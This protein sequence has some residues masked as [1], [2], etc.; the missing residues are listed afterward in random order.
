[1]KPLIPFANT[2]NPDNNIVYEALRIL[3]TNTFSGV[4]PIDTNGLW[5]TAMHIEDKKGHSGFIK[6]LIQDG[7]GEIVAYRIAEDYKYIP[8]E[9]DSELSMEH[10]LIGKLSDA[11]Q[12]MPDHYAQFGAVDH[13]PAIILKKI[14]GI[15]EFSEKQKEALSRILY[16]YSNSFVLVKYPLKLFREEWINIFVLYQNLAPLSDYIKN[17]E[18][19]ESRCFFREWIID[20]SKMRAGK[21]SK[22]QLYNTNDTSK[23]SSLLLN[24]EGIYHLIQDTSGLLSGTWYRIKRGPLAETYINRD[25]LL[26]LNITS[27]Y[28]AIKKRKTGSI[29]LFYNEDRTMPILDIK[30]ESN[31]MYYLGNAPNSNADKIPV[32][33]LLK[34]NSKTMKDFDK[35]TAILFLHQSNYEYSGYV[36]QEGWLYY[37]D[38]MNLAGDRNPYI[39]ELTGKN[40]PLTLYALTSKNLTL[41]KKDSFTVKTLN[42]QKGYLIFFSGHMFKADALPNS[43]KIERQSASYNITRSGQISVNNGKEN[44]SLALLINTTVEVKGSDKEQWNYL[45]SYNG[46]NYYYKGRIPPGMSEQSVTYSVQEPLTISVSLLEAKNLDGVPVLCF[47]GDKLEKSEEC[48]T[49]ERNPFTL[50]KVKRTGACGSEKNYHHRGFLGKATD[51]PKD[52]F[53]RHS[54]MEVRFKEESQV[55][56]DAGRVVRKDGFIIYKGDSAVSSKT[57]LFS[58]EIT[59]KTVYYEEYTRNANPLKRVSIGGDSGYVEVKNPTDFYTSRN[60][61]GFSIDSIETG[62]IRLGIE[63]FIGRQCLSGQRAIHVE[64]FLESLDGFKTGKSGRVIDTADLA[65]EFYLIK[66]KNDAPSIPLYNG[67]PHKELV[68]DPG[69]SI[70]MQVVRVYP[71]GRDSNLLK[72][73][74]SRLINAEIRLTHNR[75]GSKAVCSIGGREYRFSL[76]NITNGTCYAKP[77]V[78]GTRWIQLNGEG[79]IHTRETYLLTLIKEESDTIFLYR[80]WAHK[81]K[82]E[83]SY[84]IAVGDL[85][86]GKKEDI[87]SIRTNEYSYITL[88][89][90]LQNV[91]EGR[92][93]VLGCREDQVRGNPFEKDYFISLKDAV[94]LKARGNEWIRI[95]YNNAYYFA[96]KRNFKR[97]TMANNFWENP[98]DTMIQFHVLSLPFFALTEA[99]GNSLEC[100]IHLLSRLINNQLDYDYLRNLSRSE[101]LANLLYYG[102]TENM[103]YNDKPIPDNLY[104]TFNR[105]I[106]KCPSV[107]EWY[108]EPDPARYFPRTAMLFRDDEKKRYQDYLKSHLWMTTKVKESMGLGKTSG[109]PVGQ[110]TLFYYFHPI[111]F[112]QY[113]TQFF[114]FEFNPYGGKL[115]ESGSLTIKVVDNPGFAPLHDGRE[116]VPFYEYGNKMYARVSGLYNE[117][118]SEVGTYPRKFDEFYHEGVDFGAK[119]GTRIE[120]F[121]YGKVIAVGSMGS[122]GN[123]ILIKDSRKTDILY[124]LAHL[125]R[126]LVKEGDEVFP[127]MEVGE[128]GK[129]GGNYSPHLHLGIMKTEWNKKEHI[130]IFS[131]K[132]KQYEWKRYSQI[133]LPNYYNAFDHKDNNRRISIEK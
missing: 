18:P 41:V 78:W 71:P 108:D 65:N 100:N 105:S 55:V 132:S 35:E 1:M 17:R 117:D 67:V 113:V 70:S 6:P 24:K 2:T 129:T 110:I 83:I 50:V 53:S 21:V 75:S 126:P 51:S 38:E 43:K 39:A 122:Y 97:V 54:R 57:I 115:I 22:L 118:Y 7:N 99:G 23:K 107:W 44:I 3:E 5:H 111:N 120:S 72:I 13:P 30:K 60:R 101:R 114:N 86:F 82:P 9:H 74:P 80:I 119:E 79:F 42:N 94:T 16:S 31:F 58:D 130:V 28:Y 62:K 49:R 19:E 63:D 92:E 76:S 40:R 103:Y 131:E 47:H 124:L 85:D 127:A 68:F 106:I 15:T 46:T 29:T 112:L 128:V 52:I 125:L 81:T 45:I 109:L 91:Y 90:N 121:I 87:T 34:D 89:N 98:G 20:Q 102:N 133:P 77:E 48:Q 26:S 61:K 25:S 69:D 14:L 73:E 27:V 32:D 95:E 104:S 59:D 123:I 8:F 84:Y 33:E 4:Y 37:R 96:E 10:D 12:T 11:R 88:K 64:L 36:K 116:G 56:I 93:P 66:N